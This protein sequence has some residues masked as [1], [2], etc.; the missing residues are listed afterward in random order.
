MNIKFELY[1]FY[2]LY[3]K[4]FTYI[5]IQTISQEMHLKNYVIKNSIKMINIILKKLKTVILY[6]LIMKI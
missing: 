5:A 4:N 2:L 1:R 3:F 6:F